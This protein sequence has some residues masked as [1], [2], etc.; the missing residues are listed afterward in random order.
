MINRTFT[1]NDLSSFYQLQI[2]N[3]TE[4]IYILVDIPDRLETKSIKELFD[5]IW[6]IGLVPNGSKVSFVFAINKTNFD[7]AETIGETFGKFNKFTL[8]KLDR[9]ETE[10]LIELRLKTI[11]LNIK[12]VFSDEIIDLIFNYSKGTPR[13]IISACS[14]IFDHKNANIEEVKKIFKE[15]YSCKI[16]DDR[17][18]NTEDRLL[19]KSMLKILNID[20]QGSAKSKEDYIQTVQKQTGVGKSSIQRRISKLIEFGILR[21]YRGGENRAFKILSLND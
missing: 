21:E 1:I 13:N 18:D 2:R 9:E 10:K 11:N 3:L 16:I 17:I 20:F 8:E 19:F 4:P 15:D 5:T 6:T 7:K 12:D 14:L